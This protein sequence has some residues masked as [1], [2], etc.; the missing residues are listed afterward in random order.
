M[1]SRQPPQA[2]FVFNVTPESLSRYTDDLIQ[3]D[4]S[5]IRKITSS[6]LENATFENSIRALALSEND[7]KIRTQYI[8]LFQAVHPDAE[9][10]KASADA[11]T[12]LD[13]ANAAKYSRVDLYRIFARVEELNEPLDIESKRFLQKGLRRCMTSGASL[14]DEAQ[15]QRF[16]ALDDQIIDLKSQFAVNLTEDTTDLWFSEGELQGLSQDTIQSL[17]EDEYRRRR[18]TMK[19]PHVRAA[20]AQVEDPGVREKVFKQSETIAPL[21]TGIF[22]QVMLLRDELA[23]LIGYE[24]F[25]H[26]ILSDRLVDKPENAVAFLK[27]LEDKLRPSADVE[28]DRLKHIKTSLKRSNTTNANG[29]QDVFL[30]DFQY[31]HTTLL[32][33]SYQVD[34]SALSEYFPTQYTIPKMLESFAGLFGLD[35]RP[36]NTEQLVIWGEAGDPA[37]YVWH[38]SVEVY[39][40]WDDKL[41][42]EGFVGYLYLDLHPRDGKYGHNANFNIG[43]VSF[44]SSVER[45]QIESINW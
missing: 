27:S 13:K 30:W 17:Q 18:L 28:C 21:N 5:V 38:E 37:D 8:A 11:C 44:N 33:S 20:L 40:V 22:E 19:G 6:P 9:V 4:E 24:S 7:S 41:E 2:P 43:P 39:T 15:R 31:L 45:A 29:D 25:G 23:R 36:T 12:R 3:E 10:R 42:G 34:H 16:R 1:K 26:M 32:K 14:Q 35:I